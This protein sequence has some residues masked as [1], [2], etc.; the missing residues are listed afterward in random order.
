MLCDGCVVVRRRT[1]CC[2][3]Q[4]TGLPNPDFMSDYSVHHVGR[5]ASKCYLLANT[6]QLPSCPHVANIL[7]ARKAVKRPHSHQPHLVR[8]TGCSFWL[9]ITTFIASMLPSVDTCGP[10]CPPLKISRWA[11]FF[12]LAVSG[13]DHKVNGKKVCHSFDINNLFPDA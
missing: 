3:R 1:V 7:H 2:S 6:I 13:L 4:R 5:R 11:H 10:I 12:V 8:A 9:I